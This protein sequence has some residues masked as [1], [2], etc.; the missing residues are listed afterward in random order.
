MKSIVVVT[1]SIGGGGAERVMNLLSSALDTSDYKTFLIPI[2]SSSIDLVKPSCK[3]IR[4][5]RDKNAGIIETARAFRKYRKAVTAITPDFLILN[6]DLPELFG[7]LSRKKPKTQ[8]IVVEHTS[9]PWEKRKVMGILVR[10]I[11]KMKRTKWVVVQQKL[12]VWPFRHTS[13]VV[14]HNPVPSFYFDSQVGFD[15]KSANQPMRLIF[16]GRLT[17][18]KQTDRFIKLCSASSTPGTIIG[19]GPERKKL[20]DLAIVLNAKVEFAGQKLDPWEQVGPNDLVVITSEYEGDGL[21][22]VE[23]ILQSKPLLMPN[24]LEPFRFGL[25]DLFA[26]ASFDEYLNKIEKFKHDP[27]ILDIPK[28]SI[29][30]MRDERSIERAV[31]EWKNLLVS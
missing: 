22:I 26:C 18:E 23:A 12:S 3:V 13:T 6:C 19:D 8:I 25:P 2:N 20:E 16:I 14:I 21:V 7:A 9:R 29:K 10:L 11:L 30:K 27:G 1:N 31:K 5:E 28:S 24:H 17:P 15:E 4:L